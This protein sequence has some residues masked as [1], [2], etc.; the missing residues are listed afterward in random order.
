M[1][2]SNSHGSLKARQL[3]DC[4]AFA[5][6]AGQ[7]TSPLSTHAPSGIRKCRRREQ[8]HA[9]VALGAEDYACGVRAV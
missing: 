5:L 8:F 6:H 2:V 9:A 4:E 3:I 1:Q 7:E